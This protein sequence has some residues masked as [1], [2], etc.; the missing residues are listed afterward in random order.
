MSLLPQVKA[1]DGH[2]WKGSVVSDTVKREG[3]TVPMMSVQ[4]RQLHNQPHRG[5]IN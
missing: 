5:K 1:G 3:P 4:R 2:S